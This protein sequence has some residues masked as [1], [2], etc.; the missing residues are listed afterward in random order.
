MEIRPE[1][2]STILEMMSLV[3]RQAAM[4]AMSAELAR[5]IGTQP[6]RDAK[7]IEGATKQAREEIQQL[8]SHKFLSKPSGKDERERI[9]STGVREIISEIERSDLSA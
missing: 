3:D 9:V 4:E 1:G 6:S 5:Q 8:A 7:T 2:F